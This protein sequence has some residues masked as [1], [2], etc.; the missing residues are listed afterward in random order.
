MVSDMLLGRRLSNTDQ[1]QVLAVDSYN[2][3]R[4]DRLRHD[5][6]DGPAYGAVVA[7]EAE[8]P[9]SAHRVL[10]VVDS[11][12]NGGAE[13][14][15]ALLAMNLPPEWQP[16]I[17]SLTP[18]VWAEPLREAGIPVTVS[19]RLWRFDATPA[20]K[21]WRH[22][23]ASKPDL[24]YTQGWMAPVAA[25]PACAAL[26]I[27]LVDSRM[28]GASI[29]R[30]NYHKAK[31]GLRFSDIVI[32][33][34]AAGLA[35]LRLRSSKG[36]VIPN[37]F[38]R[39]RLVPRSRAPLSGSP[40][41]VVMAARMHQM[42][43]WDLYLA[44]VRLMAER[45]RGK[46]RFLAVGDG[47]ERP[48]LMSEGSDLVAEGS[49]EFV[50][51][52]TEV[53]PLLSTA[54]IG[55]L[56]TNPRR[57]AEGCSNSILEYMAA[58]IPVV[59]SDSGGNAELVQEGTTGFVVPGRDAERLVGRLSDLAAHPTIA[60]QMGECGARRVR[61]EFSVE[62]LVARTLAAF[63]DARRCKRPRKYQPAGADGE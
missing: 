45:D 17:W 5:H 16:Q 42:K 26:G 19:E 48:R 6:T 60:Q 28:R 50:P 31:L 59:C 44:V 10:L 58:G 14:Q 7:S 61:E 15:L 41:I 18:G 33:N 56:L 9:E 36:R 52:M 22:L 62:A 13:R 46:W 57:H 40:I 39:S 37:G 20:L 34:S 38:D 29:R 25:G 49:L 53:A 8:R 30:D 24:V 4:E 32:A 54:D 27:P 12:S 43:D 35:T 21:L 63:E 23:H 11:L 51:E 47:P 1:W 3:I 2:G 55:V